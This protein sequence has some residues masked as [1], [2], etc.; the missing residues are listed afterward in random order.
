MGDLEQLHGV[1]MWILVVKL[2]A[3]QHGNGA[4]VCVLYGSE[5][6]KASSTIYSSAVVKT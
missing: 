2:Q 3:L 6:L 1:W 5:N 4:G